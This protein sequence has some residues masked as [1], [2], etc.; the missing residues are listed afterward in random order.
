MQSIGP[1]LCQYF[2]FCILFIAFYFLSCSKGPDIFKK[3]GAI[4]TVTRNLD[5]F[6][7]LKVGEK[8]DVELTQNPN[9][10]FSA[11]IT[12]GENLLQKIETLNSKGTLTISDKNTFNWV[13]NLNLRPKVVINVPRNLRSIEISGT[14]NLIC[15]DTLTGSDLLINNTTVGELKLK[16]KYNII[17]GIGKNAG[18]SFFSGSAFLVAFTC[19]V[20]HALIAGNMDVSDF[21]LYHYTQRDCEVNAKTILDVKISNSGNVFYSKEPTYKKRAVESGEGRLMKR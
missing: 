5:S 2:Q 4:Q 9:L 6:S 17:S 11:K 15:Q 21:Y 14:A 18:T 1:K 10:P 13:R 20:G 8:F 7:A 3:T 12:F 16:G 19:D